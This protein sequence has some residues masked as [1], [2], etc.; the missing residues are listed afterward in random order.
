MPRRRLELPRPRG[1]R[2]LKPA[3]L[4]IPPPGLDLWALIWQARRL[5]YC[6]EPQLS[7]EVQGTNDFCRMFD[8]CDYC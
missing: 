8:A 4:P 2:Y 1:H 6:A 7:I 3:R 5:D